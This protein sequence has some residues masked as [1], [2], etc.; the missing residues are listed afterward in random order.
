MCK[1]QTEIKIKAPVE[2]VWET[3]MDFGAYSEWNPFLTHI[4]QIGE[5]NLRIEMTSG[6]SKM[7]FKP[8][9]I[10]IN[11]H[12]EFRWRGKLWG[13]PGIFTGEHYFLLVKEEKETR[14]IQGESF[15]G[16]L[17]LLLWPFIKKDIRNNFIKM[18]E[19]LKKVC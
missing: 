1:I 16:L 18:N 17:L 14:F 15:S 4:E 9:I 2:K 3:L 13:I 19:S 5:K 7:I 10:K 11:P 8:V 6:K 12:K